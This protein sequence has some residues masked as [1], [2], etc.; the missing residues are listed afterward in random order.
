[1]SQARTPTGP[2]TPTQSPQISLCMIVG[3]VAEYIERCLE[4]F[5]PIA[6]EVVLV[7]AIGAQKHDQTI[8]KAMN[9]VAR[10]EKKSGRKVRL[11]IGEYL[12]EKRNADWPHVDSFA[13]ARQKSFD[14]ATGNYCFWCDSDDILEAGAERIREHA[15]EGRSD[16][17]V[18]PYHIFGRGVTVPRER[19]IRRAAKGQWIYPVHECYHFDVITEGVSDE[20]CIVQHLPHTD[21]KG[22]PERN[23][24]IL[25]GIPEGEMTPG[26]YYHLH[27]ELQAAGQTVGAIEAA[28]KALACPDIGRPERYELLCNLARMSQKPE[29]ACAYLTQAYACDPCRREALGMLAASHID[30]GRPAEALAY[31]RQM[32][33]TERPADWSWNDR[34]AAYGWIGWDVYQQALR[35]NNRED[36]ADK[37]RLAKLNGA[38]GPRISL[39]HATRGRAR[40]A[41]LARKAWHDLAERPERIEHIFAMD[42]DDEASLPLQRFHTL[43][44]PAGGGCV[45][46]WNAAAGASTGDILIQ[47]S[48]DWMPPAK[49][50]TLIESRLDIAQP[51]VLA[52]SDGHR[53][54]RLLCLLICTRAYWLQDYYLFHPAFTGVYSDN[55]ATDVAYARGQVIEARDLVFFHDHPIFTGKEM[56]ET[57][58]RQNAPARYERGK[59]VYDRLASGADWSSVPGFFN[60]RLY[61]DLMADRLQDG[62]IAAEVGVWLGRSLCYLAM[63]LKEK[64]KK[65]KLIAVDGFSGEAG[66][67]AHREV[68]QAHRGNF[69][70]AFEANLERCGVRD[71]VTIIEGDSAGSAAQ[72]ADGSLAFCYIDAAHDY[73]SV[74]RDVAAWAPKVRVGGVLGGHDAQHEEVTRAVKELVP[75]AGLMPPVWHYHMVKPWKP[76]PLLSIVTPSIP[77][78]MAGPLRSLMD[79][80]AAQSTGQPVE[81]LV[82]VDNK[83]MSIGEKRQA[84]LQSARGDYVAFVDDDDAIS[85]DYVAS[86]LDAIRDR[87]GVDVLTFRQEAV[88]NGRRGGI[89]FRAGLAHDEP[90]REGATSQRRPWHVCA[91]RRE[92]ALQGRFT[93]CNYGEDRAW[94]DMVAPLAQTSAHIDR[95][96]HTYRHDTETSEALP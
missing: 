35:A 90:W 29:V 28:K 71:M 70:A 4:S 12:N 73:A 57:Y 55:W 78:R 94:V 92:L 21:K 83:A 63:R 13:A 52:V 51:Q 25:Q 45:A 41:S 14:L 8:V 74:K 81:H 59:N 91:W 80:V 89:V 37:V 47:V 62:D 5:L 68:V 56:D 79:A 72:V 10:Y 11:V 53:S 48:D 38:T 95:V 17:Y 32:L 34:G 42:D 82:M 7:R 1:M 33:A 20:T 96:L 61:Y 46:A 60:Y 40:Q 67:L 76:R 19:M 77:S 15:A 26:L 50:D 88:L 27:C 18:F 36:E 31:A 69:R 23:L 30:L 9:T 64:G 44:V 75:M 24:R 43:T 66:Q 3:N 58:L 54:D 2:T 84:L 87:P 49:W 22:S 16:V 39:L 93:P 65:V 6:D 85:P 86:L